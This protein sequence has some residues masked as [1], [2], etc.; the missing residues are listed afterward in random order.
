MKKS[1][2]AS[3]GAQERLLQI[4]TAISTE[5]DLDRLLSLILRAARRLTDA[6]SGRLYIL[7]PSGRRLIGQVIENDVTETSLGDFQPIELYAGGRPNSRNVEAYCAFSGTPVRV[8]DVQASGAFNFS[9]RLRADQQSGYFTQSLLLAPLNRPQEFTVGVLELCNARDPVSREKIAFRPEQEELVHAFASQAA[10]SIN[11]ARLLEENHR[12][13]AV[14]N[15][16]NRDLEQENQRLRSRVYGRCD[17]S[18]IIG[19][20]KPMQRLF[21]LI[22]KVADTDLTVLVRGETGVGKELV[23]QA[24]HNN[25]RRKAGRFVPQNC[26]AVPE[27][28]LESELFGYRKGAFTGATEDRQGLFEA[29]NGG[30]LFLDEIGDLP[31]GLQAKLLRALQEGEIRPL[32][33]TESRKVDVRVLAAS[34]HDLRQRVEEGKFRQDLF[35]RLQVFP[36][37]V[38]ALRERRDDLPALISHFTEG[39][40]AVHGKKIQ[41]VTPMALDVLMQHDFP[42]NVRELR[43]MLERAVVLVEDGNSISERELPGELVGEPWTQFKAVAR[44]NAET[45]TLKDA[46]DAYESKVISQRLAHLNGNRTRTAE[47]LGISRRSLQLKMSK[48]ELAEGE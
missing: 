16:S 27:Q 24:L 8:D 6:E 29:A 38:P 23:A 42:G 13:I 39:F 47:S 14:L 2:A 5:K 22:E 35:Y 36:I 30:T 41:G 11:N 40:A 37:L 32:G 19:S 3:N 28:L 4:M 7:D 44:E 15:E 46:L 1:F 33:S 12:L 18:D 20:S 45:V 26:A 21:E 48:F 10:V 25:G 43:N 9:E 17:F 34:H 31:M